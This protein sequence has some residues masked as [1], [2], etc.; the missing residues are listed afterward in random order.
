MLWFEKVPVRVIR[1][2]EATRFGPDRRALKSGDAAGLISRLSE[3]INQILAIL[4]FIEK[5]KTLKCW[6]NG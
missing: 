4:T 3:K 6:R 1:N 5:V 2:E